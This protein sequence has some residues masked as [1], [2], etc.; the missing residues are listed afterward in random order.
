MSTRSVAVAGSI[1]QCPG[2]G[3]HAWVFLNYLLGL[4]ALGHEV[5][6]ID[7][8]APDMIGSHNGKLHRSPQA[9]WLDHVMARN[10]FGYL[11]LDESRDGERDGSRTRLLERL[12]NTHLLLNVNGFLRD[13]ELLAAPAVSAFVD[14]DP[15][16]QQMWEALGLT[17]IFAGHDLHFTVGENIGRPQCAVPTCGRDWIPIRPPVAI[18]QWSPSERGQ[19]FT[20]V[21]SWRGPYGPIVYEGETFGLRAH[22]FRGMIEIAQKADVKLTVALDID[23]ADRLDADR[24]HCAGWHLLDPS[25]VAGDPSAYQAFIESSEAELSIAKNVYV[26]SRCGWFSDRSTCYLASGRP[27]LAQDTGYSENLPTGSGLISFTSPEEAAVGIE[28]I[29]RDWRMHSEA[30]RRIACEYFDASRVLK[31]MLDVADL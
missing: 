30:A 19:G 17:E 25:E 23:V 6:F 4:R 21:A 28:E 7:R 3:G 12:R 22:E 31:G 5:T 29:R 16:I 8:L 11:L 26:R 2:R 9:R 15:A 13:A 24:L 1:A 20:T 18:E 10:R 27:V 14:I